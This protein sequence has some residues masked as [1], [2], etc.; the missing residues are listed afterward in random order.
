M[1][2]EC[3]DHSAT[4]AGLNSWSHD[5]NNKAQLLVQ[6][7]TDNARLACKYEIFRG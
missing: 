1:A 7:Y 6:Y 3:A 2:A 4:W 5:K